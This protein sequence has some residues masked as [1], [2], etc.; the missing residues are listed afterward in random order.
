MNSQ[1]F[2]NSFN[3][4][5]ESKK[6]GYYSLNTVNN[7]D[8]DLLLMEKHSALSSLDFLESEAERFEE[9]ES[10]SRKIKKINSNCFIISCLSDN[11]SEMS[12]ANFSTNDY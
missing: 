5:F 8:L 6:S 2:E 4:S 10:F 12:Q 7:C 3:E 9:E 11:E 1:S